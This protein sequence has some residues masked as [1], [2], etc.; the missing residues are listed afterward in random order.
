[1]ELTRND[2]QQMLDTGIGH[3]KELQTQHWILFDE[4]LNRLSDGVAVVDQKVT[5]TN[6]SVLKHEKQLSDLEKNLPHTAANCPHTAI[7]TEL[8]DRSVEIKGE[9]KWKDRFKTVITVSLSMI[10]TAIAIFTFLKNYNP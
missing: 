10:V 2:F 3:L 4:K 7:I 9:N 8:R 1:M 6:G 5:K